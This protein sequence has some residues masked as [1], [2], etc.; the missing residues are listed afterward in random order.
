VSNTLVIRKATTAD[1]SGIVPLWKELMDFHKLRD[2]HFASAPDGEDYYREFITKH[3]GS[4][5]S[6]VLVAEYRGGLV[7]YCLAIQAQL[8]QVFAHRH[9][10]D[11]FDLAVT[12]KYRRLGVGEK[13]VAE[14]LAWFKSRGLRRVETRVA[15]TNEVSTSFWR[16]MGF[17]TFV[18]HV[19][20]QF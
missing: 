13:L 18:T 20:K 19:F 16:K 3:L 15:A 6:C 9:Y 4:T 10:G 7:G 12:L 2:M 8:P 11:I 14:A 5:N 1:V 17:R